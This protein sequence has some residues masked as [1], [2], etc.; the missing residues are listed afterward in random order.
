MTK[1][2]SNGLLDLTSKY[3]INPRVFKIALTL[4]DKLR[5]LRKRAGAYVKIN[6]ISPEDMKWISEFIT[7]GDPAKAASSAYGERIKNKHHARNK[8]MSNLQKPMIKQALTELLDAGDFED[9]K[10][11][12]ELSG[13]IYESEDKNTK[14]KGLDMAFKLKGAY[15]PEKRF[16]AQANRNFE[17]LTD[18][19]IEAEAALFLGGSSDSGEESIADEVIIGDGEETGEAEL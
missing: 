12:G 11:L 8:G 7:T 4:N 2:E 9:Q 14:L 17:G 3:P 5:R 13:C 15:A 10:L 18:D 1:K 16:I 6:V 19:E